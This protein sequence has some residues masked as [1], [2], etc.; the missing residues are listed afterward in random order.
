MLAPLDLSCVFYSFL[1]HDIILMANVNDPNR[2]IY[3]NI[4]KRISESEAVPQPKSSLINLKRIMT[5]KREEAFLTPRKRQQVA[6]IST[7]R[8]SGQL[9]NLRAAS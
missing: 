1:S 2:R 9:H 5:V 3:P 7:V 4:I 6:S 8:T